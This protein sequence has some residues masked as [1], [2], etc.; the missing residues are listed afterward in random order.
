MVIQPGE[1]LGSITP[2]AYLTVTGAAVSWSGYK[3]V[4]DEVEP[5]VEDM[6]DFVTRM[7]LTMD[8]FLETD[9]KDGMEKLA[10]RM[11]EEMVPPKLRKLFVYEKPRHYYAVLVRTG[12]EGSF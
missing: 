2:I 4:M 9:G 3:A 6:F 7:N 10:E 11:L 12:M 8:E 5:L 1:N